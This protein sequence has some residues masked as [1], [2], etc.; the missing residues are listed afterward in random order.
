MRV[1]MTTL[2]LLSPLGAHGQDSI[3]VPPQTV[4]GGMYARPY[5]FRPSS[6]IAIGGYAEGL[7]RSEYADGVHVESGFEFRRFNLFFFSSIAERISLTAELEF[8]HGTEEITLETALVDFELYEAVNLRGGILLSPLGRFNLAHDSPRN[9]FNDRPIVS[10]TII[11]STFSE[12]GAGLFGLLYPSGTTRI[13]YEAYV[14]NGLNDGILLAG[15]GTSIP[16]G[17]PGSFDGDN[18]GSPSFVGRVALLPAFGGEIGLSGHT[19]IYNTFEAEGIRI[20]EKRRATI[21]ALDGECSVGD[22]TIQ[23]EF[24]HA[25]IDLPSSL[26]GLYASSQQ[27]IYG[28]AVYTLWGGLLPMFPQ[29]TLSFGVRFDEVDMDRDI[30]GDL[31]R[32]LTVGVNLRFV[33]ETVLKLDYQHNWMFDRLNNESR[34]AGIQAGFATYF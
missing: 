32:R 27:G 21:V 33:P 9:E 5:L 7:Y 13:T 19:G 11:P 25:S 3:S 15:S 29:S 22:L 30:S 8:E 17:R 23:G 16:A 28:Q 6:G 1:A 20:D 34:G 18:N 10:T 14:V 4:S 12:A 31:I 26:T 2:L 24:A